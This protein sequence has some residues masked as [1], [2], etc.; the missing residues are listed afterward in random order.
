MARDYGLALLDSG[1][2]VDLA[3]GEAMPEGAVLMPP[4]RR[5]D[6]AA[7]RRVSPVE[8]DSFVVRAAGDRAG[9]TRIIGKGAPLG[10]SHGFTLDRLVLPVGASE[11]LPD[12][13]KFVLFV[14]EGEV[15]L[16]PD[17]RGADRLSL[18]TGDTM[19]V[20]ADLCPTVRATSAAT[21]FLVRR[22]A[23]RNGEG[24]E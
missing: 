3:A 15:E 20:P 16:D 12:E 10:W 5:E 7:M 21:L 8:A 17:W 14:H 22:E 19:S 4:T 13:G 11:R 2:L 1:R 23:E 18:G 24:G 9:R 6:A